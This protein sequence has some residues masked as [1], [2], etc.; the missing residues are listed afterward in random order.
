MM[1]EIDLPVVSTTSKE[2]RMN[3]A[4]GLSRPTVDDA[5]TAVHRV[6][7]ERGASTWSRV[8][9]DAR[10]SPNAADDES[11]DRLLDAMLAASDP[12]LGL[13]AQSLVIRRESFDRLSAA[14]KIVRSNP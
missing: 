9:A 8:L 5:R 13:C 4:Y 1:A 7:R 12:V 2:H 14:N 11:F 6:F 3:A 10:V